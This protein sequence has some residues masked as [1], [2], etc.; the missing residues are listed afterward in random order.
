MFIWQPIAYSTKGGDAERYSNDSWGVGAAF[1]DAT[2]LVGPPVINFAD[3]FDGTKEAVF[4]DNAHTN[5]LGAE[6]IA[7]DIYPHL[8][9]KR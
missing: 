7:R 9:L 6:I 5:E 2:K 4:M 1:L 3:A 8:A